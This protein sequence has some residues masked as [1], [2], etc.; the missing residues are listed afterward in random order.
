MRKLL[1]LIF[2]FMLCACKPEVVYLSEQDSGLNIN[3]SV[4]Q[5]AVITLPENPTTGFSWV[6]EF[7]PKEQIVIGNIREK[8]VH[9]KTKM[10]GSGGVKEFAFKTENAGKVDVFGY[11]VRSWEK[12]DKNKVQAVHY[13]IV[14]K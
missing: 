12:W 9:Q 5:N 14:V 6:F 10:L 11:Y 13:I 7:E 1:S 4:G 2:W 8:F 3:L